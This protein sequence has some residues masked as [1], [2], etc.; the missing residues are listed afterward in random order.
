MKDLLVGSRKGRQRSAFPLQHLD[1]QTPETLSQAIAEPTGHDYDTHLLSY[2]EFCQ[3]YSLPITPT[4]TTFARYMVF[5]THFDITPESLETYL[6]GISF[7]LRAYFPE[8][9]EIRNSRFIRD[10]SNGIKRKHENRDYQHKEPITFSQL[11]NVAASCKNVNNSYDDRLFFA[12]L[13]TGFFGLLRI[14]EFTDPNNPRLINR[15]TTI[16][17]DSLTSTQHSASF[18]LPASK[19][20]K[21]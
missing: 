14:G 10:V 18:V 19:I 6:S 4:M 9:D 12:L 3:L 20:D 2:L 17:R 11:E 8:V 5:I 1:I 16:R 13:V 21:V 15:E 7:R